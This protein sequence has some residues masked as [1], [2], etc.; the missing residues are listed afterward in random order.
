MDGG[1]SY[2]ANPAELCCRASQ[3]VLTYHH[4][5]CDRTSNLADR[6]LNRKT[7]FLSAGRGLHGHQ[8]SS[9]LLLRGWALLNLIQVR[10]Y[11]SE[12]LAV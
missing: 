8:H 1:N 7:G 4:P 5:S 12:A 9:E 6:L 10:V 2:H 11:S 3:Y